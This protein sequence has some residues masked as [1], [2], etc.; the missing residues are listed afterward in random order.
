MKYGMNLLL[1][2]D[3]VTEEHYSLLE[4]IKGW[5][6]DGVELPMFSPDVDQFKK[7]GERLRNIGL[8]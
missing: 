2:T 8:E 7:V 6:Y 1:W 5:G 3:A 4:K